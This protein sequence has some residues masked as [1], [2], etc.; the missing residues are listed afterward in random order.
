MLL[1]VNDLEVQTDEQ[2][3][4]AQACQH[5]EGPGV[6]V[7]NCSLLGLDGAVGK[8]L[9]DVGV[10][11]VEHLADEDGEEPQTDVLDPEN[12]CVGA[13]DDLGI[14]QL[15]NAGPQ[16]GGNERER[17]TQH[18]DGQVSHNKA[19]GSATLEHGQDEGERQ[20]AGNQQQRA[21][22]EHRSGFTLVVH[23]VAQ[24]GGDTHS[25]QGEYGEDAL[26]TLAHVTHVA[27]ANQGDYRH[28]QQAVLGAL[29]LHEVAHEGGGGNHEHHD[30]L[31]D[32]Q[33]LAGP[34]R[35]GINLGERQVAL[36][37]VHG[38]LLEGEDGAVVEHAQQRYQPETLVGQDLANVAYLE[39]IVLLLGLARLLIEL[40]VH[41]EV[42]DEHDQGDA[43]QNDAKGYRARN[44]DRAAQLGEVGR[45]DH[46]GGNTQAGQCHLATHGQSHLAALEPLHDTTANGDTGHLDTATKD[47]EADSGDLGAGGHALKEGRYAQLVEQGDVVQ[48]VG[49]PGLKTGSDK[50]VGYGIPLDAGTNEH[51][52]A[53]EQRGE[54]HAHLVE[55][56]TGKNQEEHKH[57]EEYLSAFLGT[58]SRRTPAAG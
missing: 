16:G 45:E 57:V 55:D 23:V 43:H 53:R 32:G 42:N 50:A 26:G 25:Q 29:V 15:G 10:S 56:D 1:A 6:V 40:A 48:V 54:A 44:V 3:G 49:K 36:Q 22:H 31:V 2:S 52:D 33:T 39:R 51:H 12:Q 41:E 30:I 18:Q 14:H 47:H 38:I 11:A 9:N 58:E 28:A 5:H 13:T 7:G 46:T 37:H 21:Q 4:N 19:G 24:N 34:E 17:R 27:V 35:V 20:V 8:T